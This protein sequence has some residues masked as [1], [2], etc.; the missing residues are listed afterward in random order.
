[1]RTTIAPSNKLVKASYD[2]HDDQARRQIL[3]ELRARLRKELPFYLR[4]LKRKHENPRNPSDVMFSDLLVGD[5]NLAAG[6]YI[7]AVV[8]NDFASRIRDEMVSEIGRK[9]CFVIREM[10]D[11]LEEHARIIRKLYPEK[12][13]PEM[14]TRQ[15]IGCW[16]S[17]FCRRRGG[18]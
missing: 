7:G 12:L 14:V 16:I 15:K 13:R 11:H 8:R 1:M 18:R 3:E 6:F 9:D 2:D 5:R 17:A 10:V 4:R